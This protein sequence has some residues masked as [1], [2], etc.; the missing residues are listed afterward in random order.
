MFQKTNINHSIRFKP[1]PEANKIYHNHHAH[2]YGAFY[3][4]T[5]KWDLRVDKD[6]F[7]TMQLWCFME[8]FG[9]HFSI[10]Y[11]TFIETTIYIECPEQ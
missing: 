3:Q 9:K 11:T 8:I 10:G 2:Y 7:C 4:P 5:K 1:L 6:G